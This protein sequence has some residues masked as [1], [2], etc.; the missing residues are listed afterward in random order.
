MKSRA[1]HNISKLCFHEDSANYVFV[2]CFLWGS[3]GK[4]FYFFFFFVQSELYVITLFSVTNLC[5]LIVLYWIRLDKVDGGR[6]RE[7]GEK[8]DKT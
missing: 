2:C 5:N 8:I 7:G 1:I 3:L 4:G 6:E